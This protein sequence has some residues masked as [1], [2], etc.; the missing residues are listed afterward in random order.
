[1]VTMTATKITAFEAE[2]ETNYLLHSLLPDRYTAG[3]ARFDAAANVWRVPVLLS[4][5]VIGPVG[6]VG[7]VTIS[8]DAPQ[9]LTHTPATEM[10]AAARVLYSQ[11]R[12]A[13]EAPV[14]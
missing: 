13:I 2:A 9:V 12:D 5:A 3:E 6:Q 4:Y 7:E 10:K 11:H 14:P 1:M 8:G